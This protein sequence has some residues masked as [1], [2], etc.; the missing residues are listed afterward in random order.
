MKVEKKKIISL[1]IMMFMFILFSNVKMSYAGEF[2]RDDSEYSSGSSPSMLGIYRSLIDDPKGWM[3]APASYWTGITSYRKDSNWINNPTWLGEYIKPGSYIYNHIDAFNT[4]NN[5]NWLI[6]G[7]YAFCAGHTMEQSLPD[8][9]IGSSNLKYIRVLNVNLPDSATIDGNSFPL[10][11]NK[12]ETAEK[13]NNNVDAGIQ[14]IITDAKRNTLNKDAL[15]LAIYAAKATWEEEN[16]SYQL[17][18]KHE[19]GLRQYMKDNYTRVV[20]EGPFQAKRIYGLDGQVDWKNYGYITEQEMQEV[21]N[22]AAGI[23]SATLTTKKIEEYKDNVPSI[24]YENVCGDSSKK[25][26]IIGPYSVTQKYGKITEIELELEDGTKKVASYYKIDSYLYYIEDEKYEQQD[27]ASNQEF[28]VIIPDEEVNNIKSIKVKKNFKNY[29]ARIVMTFGAYEGGQAICMYYGQSFQDEQ[30]CELPIPPNPT[31]TIRKTDANTGVELFNARFVIKNVDQNKYVKIDENTKEISYVDKIEDASEFKSKEEVTLSEAGKYSVLEVKAENENYPKANKTEDGAIKIGEITLAFGQKGE[32][33]AKNQRHT[34]LILEKTDETTGQKLTNTRFVIKQVSGENKDKYLVAGNPVTYVS[35]IHQATQFAPFETIKHIEI[36]EDT[37]Y[38]IYEVQEQDS[39]YEKASIDN[40]LEMKNSDG[41]PLVI[42]L[43]PGTTNT[44]N[45]NY[46][47]NNIVKMTNKRIYINV[48]GYVW[49]ENRDGKVSDNNDLYKTSTESLPDTK[50]LLFNGITVRL[51][52][53]T[54]ND[55]IVQEVVTSK[56]D[57]YQD[58]VNNGNGEYLFTN[59]SIDKLQDYYIEFEYDGLTYTNVVPH[60]DEDRGSKSAESER[61]E[62]NKNFAVVEGETEAGTRDENKNETYG[63]T[64]D[65]DEN[66]KHHLSYDVDGHNAIFNQQGSY[67]VIK[68]NAGNDEYIKQ[69]SIGEYTITAN[70]YNTY[71]GY[72]NKIK[73]ANQIREEGILEIKYINLGLYEREQPDISLVKDLSNVKVSINGYQHVYEYSKRLDKPIEPT[74]NDLNVGVQY[75]EKYTGTYYRA[76]YESDYMYTTQEENKKLEVYLTYQLRINNESD[77]LTTRVN[78]IVDYYDSNYELYQVGT[79]L[80]ESKQV[81]DDNN[82]SRT[83]PV[84]Q[85][86]YKKVIFGLDTNGDNNKI[87]H[88]KYM[89]IY[90]QFK[91]K[92]GAVEKIINDKE[93]LDNIAEIN[94]YSIFDTNGSIYA[95]IDK[96]SNPGNYIP[97]VTKTYEDDTDSSPALKLQVVAAREMT[98]KVFLDEPLKDLL[99]N[100]QIRQGSG[101]YEE[102]EK[103]IEGVYVTLTEKTTG[104]VYKTKTIQDEV[105]EDGKYGFKDN[106]EGVLVPEPYN[107]ANKYEYIYDNAQHDEKL[108]KGDFYIAN[109][110]PGDYTLTYTWGDETYT[111]QNYKGTIYKDKDRQYNVEWYKENVD[112]RLSDAI[113]NYDTRKAIDA[114]MATVVNKDT[115]INYTITK[116]DSTTPVMGIGIE[117]ETNGI[118]SIETE[119]EGDKFIPKGFSIKNIDFGI[120]ERARQDL[121]LT[122]RVKS[123]KVTLANGQTIASFTINEEEDEDGNVNRIITGERK[124]VTYEEPDESTN[125]FIRLEL[126]SELIQGARLE[127]EYEI[128]VTNQ[129][130]LDYKTKDFYIYGANEGETVDG[131]VA[132]IKPLAIIDYLDKDWAFDSEVNSQWEIK[133]I[134]EIGSLV[135]EEVYNSKESTIGEKTI[136]YTE[137]LSEK[138]LKPNESTGTMLNVSKTLTATDEIS[139]DNE[140]EI[141]KLYKEGGSELRFMPGNYVPGAGKTESDDDMAEAIIITPPTGNSQN[142]II[143][144]IIGVTALIILAVGVVIIKK[145]AIN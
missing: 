106:G 47:A 88:G 137:G 97:G 4:L 6:N 25:D 112:T 82:I 57:R 81:I 91:L 109:Y 65:T 119:T 101:A 102:G 11:D 75:K 89:D 1:V 73:E 22:L 3:N 70:T 62:F 86:S 93:N 67:E 39:G 45:I 143:P 35:D 44:S 131:D 113:D 43:K 2:Y 33:K 38:Q 83:E 139:L 145:K 141:V 138:N 19:A 7:K 118:T 29:Q 34:E 99:D 94:S 133:G 64:K 32:V 51:K 12:F 31:L 40:P 55:E 98:G 63:V 87:E 129:S 21:D 134:D 23:Q 18:S 95:G 71:Q 128:K 108:G 16:T 105:G 140:T 92:D 124:N 127:V 85:G 5:N 50:D 123:M 37:T 96:D 79:K 80:D 68:D 46:S 49:V 53:S 114:E 36:Y 58:S 30:T 9:I 117:E 74:E 107:D 26:T 54:K 14:T 116:M 135:A 56:L 76:I 13:E 27:V 61:N 8:P 132:T 84:E 115:K 69:N 28:Y 60:I 20:S 59:V 10:K 121:A 17:I 15:T 110:I 142:Y 77:N 42:T 126:D 120:V 104:K 72:L 78:S 48:S 130:E 100:E 111:V 52:D 41:S 24:T 144:I 122:K 90:V 136:L 103:G 66:V 125:G